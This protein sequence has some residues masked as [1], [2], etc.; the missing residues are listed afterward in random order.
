MF[1]E[2][3][4]IGDVDSDNNHYGTE[5][6]YCK[7]RI[8]RNM[9]D[10]CASCWNIALQISW[11]DSLRRL[12]YAN[13]LPSLKSLTLQLDYDELIKAY[14]NLPYYLK[15]ISFVGGTCSNYI[16]TIRKAIPIQKYKIY[17]IDVGLACFINR[18]NYDVID[19]EQFYIKQHT[20]YISRYCTEIYTDGSSL[21]ECFDDLPQ[22]WDYLPN[23]II[24]QCL[25]YILPDNLPPKLHTAPYIDRLD[26]RLCRRN[27]PLLIQKETTH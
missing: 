4:C 19:G 15:I 11:T 10:I 14:T 2:W 23:T 3:Y 12:D 16:I 26:L 18:Y 6:E 17:N 22:N 20:L 9:G 7:C 21:T 1:Q 13:L 25:F 27:A 5:Y 8:Y 24:C